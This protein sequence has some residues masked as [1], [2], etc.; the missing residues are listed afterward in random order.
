M[1]KI[2]VG[3]WAW[4]TAAVLLLGSVAVPDLR[5]ASDKPITFVQI[6]DTHNGLPVHAYRFRAAIDAINK[7][8]F[9]IAVVAHTGDFACDDLY[10]KATCIEITNMLSRIKKPLICAPGNH[11]LSMKGI[12]PAKRL[13]DCLKAYTTFIG[14]LGQVYETEDAVFIAVCTEPLRGTI[15]AIPGFDPIAWMDEQL[16]KTKGKPVFV[17]THVPDGQ[18]FYDNALHDGWP[19]ANRQAWHKVLKK[20]DVKAVFCG[21]Y[22]RDE[23]QQNDDGIPVFV[24]NSIANFW[25]RQASFRIYTYEKGRLSFHTVYIEDPAPGRIINPDGT[26]AEPVKDPAA[27]G[28]E[29]ATGE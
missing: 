20:G 11:D 3:G 15:P 10:K 14:P 12:D 8:P 21:H 19:E 13:A 9:D 17:F 16:S 23:L 26:L 7:L 28:R 22:H 6:T 1:K 29:D 24:A 27:A 25:G 18:D 5:A 4:L 2:I